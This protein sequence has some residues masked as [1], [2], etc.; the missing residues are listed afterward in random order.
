MTLGNA[1]GLVLTTGVVT[2]VINQSLGGWL[3]GRRQRSEQAHQSAMQND[4]RQHERQLRIEQAHA[5]ARETFLE[6][7]AGSVDWI[8]HEWGEV[9]GLDVDWV[10]ENDPVPAFASVTEAIEALR[11]VELRHP[12]R[13][14]RE[15]AHAL[16]QSISGEYGSI[17]TIWNPREG[18]AEQRVGVSPNDETFRKWSKLGEELIDAVHEPPE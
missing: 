13:Q 11:R 8:D 17:S 14:V 15:L 10:G 2:A 12:T 3:A 18:A 7:V 6:D 9:H 4:Q 1:V 16:R 5:Q